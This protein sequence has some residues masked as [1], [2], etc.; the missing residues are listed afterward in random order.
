MRGTGNQKPTFGTYVQGGPDH[1]VL[2][3]TS[4]I[5]GNWYHIVGTFDG[6]N[7]KIYINGVLDNTKVDSTAL[8]VG[9]NLRLTIGGFDNDGTPGRFFNGSLDDVRIK[10]A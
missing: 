1:H 4:L 10:S 5:V 9:A 6:S 3:N 7:Y 2:A 8:V